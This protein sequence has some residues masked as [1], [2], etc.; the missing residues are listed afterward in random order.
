MLHWAK[1]T[2]PTAIPIEYVFS[3]VVSSV[4][5]TSAGRGGEGREGYVSSVNCIPCVCVCV[6]TGNGGRDEDEETERC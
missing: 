5:P 3:A 4:K 6:L 2:M 1:L